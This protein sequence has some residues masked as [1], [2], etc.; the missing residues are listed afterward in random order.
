MNYSPDLKASHLTRARV[1]NFLTLCMLGNFFKYLF[2]SKFS[3]NSL[4]YFLWR[5]QSPMAVKGLTYEGLKNTALIYR[6]FSHS[7]GVN[8]THLHVACRSLMRTLTMLS[9]VIT[10]KGLPGIPLTLSPPNKLS[11]AKFLFCFNI[12]LE[13]FNVAQSW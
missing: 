3:K 4:H 11:S 8:E 5:L 2:L 1:C 9:A 6:T 7:H 13:C 10:R 12:Y